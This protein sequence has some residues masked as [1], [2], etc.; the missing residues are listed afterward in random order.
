MAL[1]ARKRGDPKAE[2]Y[3]PDRDLANITPALI[4]QTL[5]NA[6]EKVKNHPQLLEQMGAAATRLADLCASAQTCT[7]NPKTIPFEIQSLPPA[8][9]GLLGVELLA[10]IMTKYREF[11]GEVTLA[12]PS[13][14]QT[15][16][17]ASPQ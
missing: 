13:Q 8:I 11:A 12:S 10:L 14:P 17:E 16:P 15:Q 3:R 6:Q 2:W 5:K 1:Q 7:L 4:Q 9:S